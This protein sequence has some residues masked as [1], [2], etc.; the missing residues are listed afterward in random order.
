VHLALVALVGQTAPRS[1][2]PSGD[3]AVMQLAVMTELDHTWQAVAATP[4]VA[5]RVRERF[6]AC[7]ATHF[8]TAQAGKLAAMFADRA[9]L[10][11]LPINELVSMTVRN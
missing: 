9:K 8:P 7:V 4:A 5:D 1:S 3:E 2:S 6:A 11:A 10:E